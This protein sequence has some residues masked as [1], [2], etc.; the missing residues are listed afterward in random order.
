MKIKVPK[1]VKIGAHTYSVW[2]NPNLMSDDRTHGQINH[3]IERIIIQ[4]DDPDMLKTETLIHEIIH[5]GE[6]CYRIPIED[7]D[8]D[9]IAEVILQFLDQLGIKFSWDDISC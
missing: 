9:R 6:F 8:I 5:L 2:L 3:R 4:K 1:Q 7:A